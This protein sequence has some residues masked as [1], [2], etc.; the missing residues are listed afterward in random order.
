MKSIL[1]NACFVALAALCAVFAAACDDDDT[2]GG[3]LQIFYPTV[4]DIG[5][6]MNFV[7][8]TPTWKGPAPTAFS[9]AGITLD[10]RAVETACF[11]IAPETGIVTIADTDQLETGVYKLSVA[12]QAAGRTYSFRDV[13]EVRM[14]PAIPAE[15]EVSAP[16]LEI[17]YAELETTEEKVAVT[18]VGESVTILSYELVQEEGREYFAV[19]KKGEV[20]FNR[21]F[22][23]EVLPGNYPLPIRLTTYAGSMTYEKLLTGRITS[24]PLEVTYPSASGRME[25]NMSFQS[26]TPTLKGSPDETV[27]AIRKVE[28]ATDLIRIDPATGVISVDE[29]NGFAVDE[30]FAIDLTV[31]NAFGSTD[32]EGAFRLTVIDYIAPIEADKFAYADTEA[33]Q[34]GQFRVSKNDGF[35]GDEVTF[36]LGEV[37]AAV[38]GQITIDP[39]TGD[40]SAAKGHAIP[41]GTYEIPVVAANIKGEA[42]AVL[43]L[44][45][46]ENPYYFTSIH[47]GNNLG[48]TPAENYASQYRCAK[49]ADLTALELTPTTDAKP[50][51]QLT[52]SIK[53][54]HQCKGTNIDSQTGVIRPSG[55]NA[56]NGG[57]VLVTATAGE[58]E[59]GETSVTVPIFFSFI[60]E[61]EGVTIH[62]TPFVFQVNP[63]RGG[64][65]VAPTVTGVE[66]AQF[67]IDYRRTFNY[68]NIG[69]PASHVDGQPSVA[70]SFMNQMYT[71]YFTSIGAASVNTGSKDPVSYYSN[72]SRLGSA[73]LYVDPGTKSVVVNANKWIDTNNAAA[74]G[75]FIGQM[76][77]V[78]DGTPGN[79]NNGTKTFPIWIWF[80]E[81]F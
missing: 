66:P 11:T 59:V 69:G 14:V 44:T 58:G 12:C 7:S 34:G 46:K 64:T 37:P 78:T 21:N 54:K 43:R 39:T 75:A 38:A 15:I 70:G 61:Q 25:Y 32:F 19:S 52:W 79:V 27:W 55:F 26:S 80:D 63:R 47:Y 36:S 28:P 49:A 65:S 42:T 9:I 35:V 60:Q 4:V 10:D 5:P 6:S 62:Y 73:L 2:K 30:V 77:F 48:L 57:L 72:S 23:G 71:S 40:V 17:P 29:G 18:P 76:T 16:T 22:Q 45:V 3:D 1:R 41:I 50:G 20:T 81:K 8:G 31:T 74:N 67:L 13:F 53:I 51:T 56:N 68:Y 24:A 33:I